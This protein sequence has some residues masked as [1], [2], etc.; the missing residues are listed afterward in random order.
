MFIDRA[1]LPAN[2]VDFLNEASMPLILPT[3]TSQFL[4]AHMA[5][6]GRVSAAALRANA[7]SAR[8]WA[9]VMGGG[10]PV[11][12]EMDALIRVADIYPG[13][14]QG[15]DVFGK[16]KGDTV[17][18]QRPVY[19]VGGLTEAA[20]KLNK[21]TISTTTRAMQTEEVPIV[22][23]EFIGPYAS[24][25]SDVNPFGV[26]NFDAT[27]KAAKLSTAGLVSNA[28]VYD[29][30]SWLDAVIRNRMLLS[31]YTTLSDKSFSD[32]TSYVPGGGS[33]FSVEQ[34]FRARQAITDRK[35]RKFPNGRFIVVVPTCFQSHMLRDPDFRE[36]SVQ[37]PEFNQLYG[38]V[39]SI[40]D[41]DFYECDTTVTYS[42]TSPDT[43]A[44]TGD[45][46]GTVPTGVKLQEAIMIG[47]GTVGFGTCQD[48]LS[49]A[50]GPSV[51]FG[52]TTNYQTETMFIWYAL[53][54]FELLDKRGV[55]RLIAQSV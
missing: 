42:D 44:V 30:T 2:Y 48:P 24:D 47:P 36:M 21:K 51:R 54:A 38:Y 43:A 53:H 26:W 29:Y 22:L 25:G 52:D 18:F 8:E 46:A 40:D 19:S 7:S 31:G 4:F 27:I 3:P 15:V 5:M 14:V 50:M 35:W 17:K 12:P 37:H 9:N 16:G 55:Q 39:T 41:M 11:P 13:I 20:R 34:L 32:V 33:E 23:E 45:A 1:S 28:L 49:G 6:A 10:A